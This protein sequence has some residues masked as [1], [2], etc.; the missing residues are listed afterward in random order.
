MIWKIQARQVDATLPQ[1][2]FIS[3]IFWK[4]MARLMLHIQRR[5]FPRLVKPN[6][7]WLI[8]CFG[9][10]KLRHVDQPT[11]VAGNV[12]LR[13]NLPSFPPSLVGSPPHFRSVNQPVRCVLA[14]H[15]NVESAISSAQESDKSGGGDAIQL[16]DSLRVPILF[17]HDACFHHH[18]SEVGT[19][20]DVI[21]MLPT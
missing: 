8:R 20:V 18:R 17:T 11:K 7:T 1:A 13:T 4:E 16:Q 19:V 15:L 2:P 9:C 21:R 5:S 14:R 3:N 6:G 12:T 10:A